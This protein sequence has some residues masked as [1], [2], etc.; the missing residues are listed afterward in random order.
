LTPSFLACVTQGDFRKLE[1]RVADQGQRSATRP[2]SA[3]QIAKL[4]AEVD[5]L[6]EQQRKL[7]GEL[8]VA[9]KKADKALEEARKARQQV[10]AQSAGLATSQGALAESADADFPDDDSGVTSEEVAAYQK[11]L[12]AWRGD[13]QKLCID[14][15]RNF[16]QAYPQSAYADDGAYWL[17][18]CHFKQGDYRAAVLRF[19]DVVQVYPA[20]NK[21]ADALYRQGESLLKLGPGFHDAAKTAFEQVV[22]DYPESARAREAEKQLSALGSG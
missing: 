18:D 7:G 5:A 9:R 20:G 14:R 11:A 1:E 22:K 13:D 15:F 19:N 3:K 16:L 4:S 12:E 17:A 2:N 10:A 21:A 6:R 8:D